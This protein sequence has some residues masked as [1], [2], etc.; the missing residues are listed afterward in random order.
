MSA[1]GAGLRAAAAAGASLVRVE[2]VKFVVD[3]AAC[4]VAGQD[5]FPMVDPEPVLAIACPE[6]PKAVAR[7]VAAARANGW[8]LA[9]RG[10][11]L[12][13]TGAYTSL[14]PARTIVVSVERL[15]RVREINALD[16]YVLV[17][18]GCTWAE[19]DAALAPLGL[20]AAF[21][22]PVSGRLATV[23]GSLS[24][25]GAFWGSGRS[26]AAADTALGLEVVTGAGE[27][28]RTGSYGA[29]G[30][31]AFTRHFGPDLLG[32]FL[33]DCGSFGI[34]TAA[35]LR[36]VPAL[37]A[38][39]L[40]FSASDP[41]RVFRFL[42]ELG[43]SG[44]STHTMALDA[45]LA[46]ER[47]AGASVAEAAG[48]LRAL[49][50]AE[51]SAGGKLRDLAALARAGAGARLPSAARGL[52]VHVGIEA[53]DD[54]ANGDGLAARAAKVSALAARHG[55]DV[56]DATIGKAMLR[57]KFA[58]VTGL[59]GAKGERWVPVHG[60]LPHSRAAE[61]FA[62]VHAALDQEADA[63]AAKGIKVRNLIASVGPGALVV[64][65]MFLWKDR[66]PLLVQ[67]TLRQ[68]TGRE[69]AQ[70]AGQP[71]ATALVRQL[72]ARIVGIFDAHGASHFQLGSAY[73]WRQRLDPAAAALFEGI[74]A[75]LDPDRVFIAPLFAGA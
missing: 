42:A 5:I 1:P 56:A 67:E 23:G 41:A 51:G 40:A 64:E 15:N 49:A 14:E 36:L 53:A 61:A 52:D 10:A 30:C 32:L 18:T 46:K 25:N 70:A 13:Y 3:P 47:L 57:Q 19:L 59:A 12:S 71:D 43:A 11:G 38:D 35:A 69:P 62:A 26:G 20:S 2:G 75:M 27:I 4:L 74:R 50:R 22:G 68:Q 9:P 31:N 29:S 16:G 63:L 39:S 54:A 55:L 33:G 65:P 73:P 60:L 37:P 8:L 7:L 6:D 45:S 58:P 44:L 17:E 24:M 48:Q 66:L 28:V 34:K 21:A 72:R